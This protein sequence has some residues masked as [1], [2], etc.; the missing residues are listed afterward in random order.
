MSHFFKLNANGVADWT[1]VPAWTEMSVPVP[2][3]L[4]PGFLAMLPPA[5]A[6]SVTH[7]APPV[8]RTPGEAG[9]E[10]IAFD[11]TE[12]IDGGGL[13]AL[14]SAPFGGV[15]TVG[16]GT[17]ARLMTTYTSG[18]V[19]KYNVTVNFEGVSS[20]ST[21]GWTSAL[22]GT[23]VGAAER[24]SKLIVGDVPPVVINGRKIDDIHITATL[25]E[26]DGAG[27]ILGQAG[28]TSVRAISMLPSTGLMRFDTADAQRYLG[29]GLFDEIVT[30]EMLHCI[31]YGTLWK[32]K[33]LVAGNNFIGQH[34]VAA[35]NDL[36]DAYA[37]THNGS[38]TLA[39]GTVLFK[40]LVPL[41]TSGGAGTAGSHWSENVFNT[42]MMTGYLDTAPVNGTAVAPLSA[43][44]MASLR[45]LGYMTGDGG[46]TD[47]FRLV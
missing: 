27:G 4:D 38:T 39:N 45:D 11:M 20:Q 44:T 1:D 41:E 18:A 7:Q 10:V 42:E 29:M 23:F 35:Y 34:A 5:A 31:G 19:G 28:M 12:T 6:Q 8:A 40:D 33:G 36:V 25:A 3:Q 21:G 17:N 43:M 37:A 46:A 24:I 2:L 47:A 13:S 9:E 30:H 15:V 26:I 32:A 16:T 22:Q 14:R